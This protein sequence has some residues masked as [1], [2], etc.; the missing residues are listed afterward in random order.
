MSPTTD[1]LPDDGAI[2]QA[3]E[4]LGV[5]LGAAEAHGLACGLLCSLSGSRAKSRWFSELV[6]AGGLAP[7]SLVEHTGALRALDA[8]G[9]DYI[10]QPLAHD[11]V[12]DH[13]ELQATLDTAICLDESI[14]SAVDARKALERR[15]A[16]VINIKVGRVGGH[17][18]ARA[19]H[20][21]SAAFGAPVWCG[22]MLES[23]IGRAH[24]IHLATLANFTRPGDT[25]SASRYFARDIVN[26]TLDA[27]RGEM[28]VPTHGPGIGVTL[29]EDYLDTVTGHVE[30]FRP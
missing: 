23:G 17:A 29:D 10:E 11:D 14:R 6:E 20:D 4:A 1:A 7:D 19:V 15:A 16:R 9:L 13:V 28:A 22:G 25:A 26:E 27:V 30:R 2:E 3:L 24:N 21:V 5:P 8:C 18:A 12:L